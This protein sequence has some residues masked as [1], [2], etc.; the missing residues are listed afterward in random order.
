MAYDPLEVDRIRAKRKAAAANA[1]QFLD[2]ANK[3]EAFAEQNVLNDQTP[4]TV[5]MHRAAIQVRFLAEGHARNLA[6]I[7]EQPLVVGPNGPH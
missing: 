5:K 2:M 4:A 1:Q 6:Q 3:L 7:A